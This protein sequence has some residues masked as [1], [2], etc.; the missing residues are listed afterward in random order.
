M[1]AAARSYPIAAQVVFDRAGADHDI[2]LAD[3]ILAEI[4]KRETP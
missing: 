2:G 3:N 1:M 4:S